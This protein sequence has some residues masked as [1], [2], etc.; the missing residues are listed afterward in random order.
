MHLNWE[1]ISH[2]DPNSPDPFAT[3][4]IPLPNYGNYGGANYSAG[5]I[6]GHITGTSADPPP[7]D[8]LDALFYQHDLVYQISTNPLV[9][10]A[11]DVQLIESMHA[12]TYTDPGDTHYD[13]E[14]GLYEGLATLGLVAQLTAGGVLP[15]LPASDQVL[16]AA[17]TREAVVNIEA[18]LAVIPG[19]AKSVHGAFHLFEHRFLDKLTFGGELPQP[20]SAPIATTSTAGGI[21]SQLVQAMAGFRG[22]SGAADGLNA[23]PLG[24]DTS[25]QT[26]LT[27]P[28]HA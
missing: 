18:G 1:A 11:A 19:E 7:V 27:T 3:H 4:G 12:L 9:R 23:A 2:F 13:P 22:G 5:Q 25:Q 17:A 8:Q 24:A 26:L 6:G 20:S 28:Q 21:S 10:A 16:I 15:H 14:A